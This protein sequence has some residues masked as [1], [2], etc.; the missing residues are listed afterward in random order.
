MDPTPAALIVATMDTKG[1]EAL[2]IADCLKNE[3][4]S[5]CIMDA[6]IKGRSPVPVDIRREEVAKIAGR[7]LAEVQNI[8]QEGQALNIMTV[9]AERQAQRLFHQGKIQGIIGLGGSMGTTL[10]TGVMRSFPISHQVS[11]P[12]PDVQNR[13]DCPDS[14]PNSV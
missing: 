10:A 2:F 6:G 9:G 1:R 14:T 8:Q 5:A 7:T 4:I 11:L 13:F 3:G 12:N